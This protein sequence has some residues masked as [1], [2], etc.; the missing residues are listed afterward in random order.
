[1]EL[2]EILRYCDHTLLRPEAGMEEIMQLCDDAIAFH[3]ASVCIPPCHVA[4]AKRYVGDQIP[5][6]T[7]IGFPHGNMTTAAKVFE[8]KDA[9]ANGAD[10]LDVVV[11]LSMVK[12]GN[13]DLVLDELRK[14]RAATPRKVLKVIIET[15]LLTEEEKRAL[16]TVVARSGA[17]YIKTSTGF[18]TGGATREDV[19][20]LRAC[21]PA[22]IQV[23]AAGGISS[24]ADA[25]D[26]L[27]LGATR[28]GTS[29]LVKLAKQQG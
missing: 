14:L 22:H 27:A 12:D 28:L 19:A 24:L 9:V 15:C 7:V 6:C 17:D 29:R 16:C 26:F 2:A 3:C 25:Q 10:E 4:G 23:K 20:L 18:S 1:M 11:N 8:G 21:C 5:V 13:Y